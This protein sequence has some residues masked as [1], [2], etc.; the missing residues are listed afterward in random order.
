MIIEPKFLHFVIHSNFV[1]Q[2][3]IINTIKEKPL[4]RNASGGFS[5]LLATLNF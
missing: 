5:F 2:D 3:R 4:G 1:I